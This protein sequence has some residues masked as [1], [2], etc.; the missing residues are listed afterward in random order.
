[1]S[2]KSLTWDIYDYHPNRYTLE[3]LRIADQYQ[4]KRFFAESFKSEVR[5][6]PS[7]AL[8]T[9]IKSFSDENVVEF[10]QLAETHGEANLREEAL[11]FMIQKASVITGRL[12]DSKWKKN[13]KDFGGCHVNRMIESFK[14]SPHLIC[15]S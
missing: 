11:Q 12:G 9:L 6:K 15:L 1:M 14:M 7:P 3:L 13:L 4:V 8:K 2:K 10:W 5:H